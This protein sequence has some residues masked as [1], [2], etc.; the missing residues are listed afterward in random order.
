MILFFGV[1][2]F[3]MSSETI[4]QN[5]DRLPDKTKSSMI[6][7][8]PTPEQTGKSKIKIPPPSKL[9]DEI[10]KEINFVRTKPADYA[11]LLKEMSKYYKG[12]I[13]S[14]PGRIPFQTKEGINSLNE[15][16]EELQAIE[17]LEPL[18]GNCSAVRASRE[19]L[20]DLQKSGAFSHF[21]SD[22]STPQERLKKYIE[23][24]SFNSENLVARTGSAREI[25]MMM[26]LDDGVPS[27]IHRKNLLNPQF[28]FAGVSNGSNAKKLNLTIVVFSDSGADIEPCEMK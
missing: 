3:S 6:K 16:I 14:F 15:A 18:A 1:L 8:E 23:G 9:E 12:T 13:F 26:L 17:P 22:G 24:I 7:T 21:G 28:R 27:R 11:N 2:F 20:A 10:M 25:I 19:H 4:A 5:R